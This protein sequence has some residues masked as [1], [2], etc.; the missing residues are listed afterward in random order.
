M[1][2]CQAIYSTAGISNHAIGFFKQTKYTD[3]HR[4]NTVVYYFPHISVR[5]KA[6]NILRND[7]PLNTCIVGTITRYDAHYP[8]ILGCCHLPDTIDHPVKSALIEYGCLNEKQL[9]KAFSL[10]HPICQIRTHCSMSNGI[11]DSEFLSG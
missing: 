8:Y 9:F 5:F 2:Y 1:Q 10:S 11:K 3:E 4:S 6:G 7:T